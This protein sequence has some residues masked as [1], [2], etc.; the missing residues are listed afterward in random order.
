MTD[1]TRPQSRTS[2][3][4]STWTEESRLKRALLICGVALGLFC[5]AI[6]GVIRLFQSLND[7]SVSA[8][9]LAFLFANIFGCVTVICALYARGRER[10][11][12]LPISRKR[13]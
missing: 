2:Q 7:G 1:Q 12:P 3:A 9:R 10:P 13:L 8:W 5:I 6:L 4:S 11:R